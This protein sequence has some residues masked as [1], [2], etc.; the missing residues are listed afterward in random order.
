MGAKI[1]CMF[2]YFFNG[3]ISF[4]RS[5]NLKAF[6]LPLTTAGGKLKQLINCQNCVDLLLQIKR[7]KNRIKSSFHY[8][9]KKK[10]LN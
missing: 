5:K 8:D 9:S 10:K 6:F 4:P 1:S 3:P 7:T 2:F